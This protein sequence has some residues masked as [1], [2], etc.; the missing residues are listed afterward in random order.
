MKC[1]SR[2]VACLALIAV[3]FCVAQRGVKASELESTF[4]SLDIITPPASLNEGDLEDTDTAVIFAERQRV[5]L[6]ADLSV[7]A[8]N[9][10]AEVQG[11]T[12]T[13]VAGVIPAGRMVDSYLVHFDPVGQPTDLNVTVSW[14]AIFE[15]GDRILGAI[16]SDELLDAS[17]FL[18][19]PGTT[20]P[21]GVEF[22]G[23]T[24]DQEGNDGFIWGQIRVF[25]GLQSVTVAVDQFRIILQVPEP[26]SLA[27]G[28]PVLFV[29]AF[30]RRRIL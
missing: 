12:N 4:G 2:F 3:T 13:A 23:T 15:F 1:S 7:D 24:G 29:L 14:S 16:Y 21:T 19:A 11:S 10:G 30:R 25:Q 22:R 8:I 27:M 20:Y 5:L 28:A 6:A 26:T 17:D 9:F 18:G